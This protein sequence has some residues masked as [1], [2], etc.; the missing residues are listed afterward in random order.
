M[1]AVTE[2]DYGNL[3]QKVEE[4]PPKP[5]TDEFR[6]FRAYLTTFH[7]IFSYLWIFFMKRT[8]GNAY[9]MAVI[10]DVNRSNARR[11][12]RTL[13]ALQGLFIKVGQLIS[14]M[15]NI[16]PDT[17][18]QELEKLQDK[19]TPRPYSEINKRIKL[20]FGASPEELFREFDRQAIAS[21]SLGQVHRAVLKTG[22]EVAVK[23]Q[24]WNIDRIVIKDLKTIRRIMKIIQFF[25]PIQGLDEYYEQIRQMIYEELDF[26]LEAENIQ[27]I[28]TN[29]E[30]NDRVHFPKVYGEYSTTKV[31][32]TSF[33]RGA[34]VTD[35]EA[36]E[37]MGVD[38]TKL[39]NLIVTTYCQM[40]FVDGEYHADPH[41]GNILVHEDNSITFL[42]FGAVASLSDSTKEGI[43]EFLEG[44][45]RR[46]TT[47]IMRALNKMG[48]IAKT[49]SEETS[50]TIIEYFHQ[51]FAE[52]IKIESFNLKDVKIDPEVGLDSLLDLRKMNIGIREMTSSFRVPRD[53]VMLERCLLLL[54][55]LVCYL[56]KELNPTSIIYPYLKDFVLGRDRD[57][58]AIVLDSLKEAAF[59]YLT[60]PQE[61]RRMM[62]KVKR[63]EITFRLHGAADRE[64]YAHS[65]GRQY[66]YTTFALASWGTGM[67]FHS[68]DILIAAGI[69]AGSTLLF[70]AL[71]F[72]S[73]LYSRKF[74][75]KL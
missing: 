42:D 45:I 7:V 4:L 26:S 6:F 56:D 19:I 67:Y 29:F 28:A 57:W 40:I 61:V 73:S 46:N 49:G 33:V 5:T 63:G 58:Q 48:F 65:R 66:I 12:Q 23:V 15:T 74:R 71:L 9:F 32:T 20:E 10:E 52:E 37:K 55:G 54:F 11:V 75:K 2:I 59:S 21:A 25:F 43:P 60:L 62:N 30:G 53:W 13:S 22:D 39:S 72:G 16:L 41:P 31:L 27:L 51:R 64:K 18:R 68:Q 69:C 24:H 34:K 8:R 17:Y 1:A 47:Q 14:I 38:R 35:L 36:L 50:E 44:L 3:V 70:L